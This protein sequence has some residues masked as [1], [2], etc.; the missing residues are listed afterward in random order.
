MLDMSEILYDPDVSQ[1]FIVN[2]QTGTWQNG[3]FVE[4]G[5]PILTMTGAVLPAT[6]KQIEQLPEGDRVTGVMA[7][8]SDK[9]IYVTHKDD[10]SGNAGTSDQIEWDGQRYRVSK[11]DPFGD[12]GF[13]VA[14]GVQMGGC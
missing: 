14:Y 11:V 5:S 10:G 13:Y 12:Y 6:P 3:R 4:V 1:D 2:R 8:Y 7:F 9:K